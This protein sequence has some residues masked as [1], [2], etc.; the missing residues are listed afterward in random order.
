[1]KN[2]TQ[3]SR[4]YIQL[5]LIAIV[6]SGAPRAREARGRNPLL[7]KSTHPRKFGTH[8]TVH[9]P[10]ARRPSAPQENQCLLSHF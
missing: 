9:R 1:M 4:S 2:K 7:S 3:L 10:T 8:V 6:F 5:E